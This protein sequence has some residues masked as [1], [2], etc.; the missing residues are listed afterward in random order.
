[1]AKTKKFYGGASGRTPLTKY[2]RRALEAKH[3]GNNDTAKGYLALDRERKRRLSQQATIKKK[4]DRIK[5]ATEDRA[6]ARRAATAQRAT[7]RRAATARRMPETAVAR[8]MPETAAARRI[9]G[10]AAAIEEALREAQEA[11]DDSGYVIVDKDDLGGG[12]F[13]GKRSRGKRSR[14]RRRKRRSRRRHTRK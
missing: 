12:R 10:S 3:R 2:Q 13:R 7:G 1:M 4:I 8:R 5:R 6:T 9:P 11:L 14:G